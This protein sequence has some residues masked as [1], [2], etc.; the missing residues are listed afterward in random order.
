M[1]TIAN[2]DGACLGNPGPGGWAW[3]VADGPWASGAEAATT[4]QRMELSAALDA[5][6]SI[7][8]RL[9]V[10]SDSKYVVDCFN[11]QWWTGWIKR[12]WVNSKKEPVKNRDLW[13][14]LIDDVR[15]RGD[16]TFEWVKGHSGDAMND[17]V[18]M[19]AV[20]AAKTQTGRRGDHFS[21]VVTVDL[22][23]DA[24][25]R[26]IGDPGRDPRL[27]GRAL[28]VGGIRPSELGGYG[29]TRASARVRAEL[30]TILAAKSALHEDL[31]VLTGLGLGVEQLAA[32]AAIDALVPFVAVLP[33]RDF[34]S[35]WP[36]VSRKRYDELLER[37]AKVITLRDEVPATKQ[38]AGRLI[39]SRDRWLAGQASE[40]IVVWDGK[41]K[42]VGE[43][44]RAWEQRF[45]AD[46]WVI[47]VE[48]VA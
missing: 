10:R 31:V 5:V 20:E 12:G 16:V 18:D 43:L 32:E 27:T 40:A 46:L 14:P 30:A 41:D 8:D 34:G 26:R 15:R 11:Q 21:A 39:G 17:A 47:E 44:V 36:V 6:R 35:N 24:P 4:N 28:A 1:T 48:A 13:E 22:T 3:A 25:R 45:D 7:S 33:F 23:E 38:I 19:L 37:A 29:D 9:V 42:R 2:T